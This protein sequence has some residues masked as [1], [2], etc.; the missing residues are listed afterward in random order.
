[1][2]GI[3]AI[4]AGLS[5]MALSACTTVSAPSAGQLTS[6]QT[7]LIKGSTSSSFSLGSSF[8]LRIESVDGKSLRSALTGYP[9]HAEL[10]AGEHKLVIMC[11]MVAEM[12]SVHNMP[13]DSNLDVNLVAGHIYQL[14]PSGKAESSGCAAKMVDTADQPSH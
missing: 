12:G 3:I 14:E 13:A 5:V 1:M 11:A 10:P 4:S 6:D 9:D 8:D 7:A 2:R